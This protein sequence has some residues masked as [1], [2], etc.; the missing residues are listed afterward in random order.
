VISTDAATLLATSKDVVRRYT[1]LYEVQQD[2][3]TR[4]VICT[5]A[6]SLCIGEVA[7]HHVVGHDRLLPPVILVYGI[8]VRN[9][10]GTVS[11]TF[12]QVE[13]C[14]AHCIVPCVGYG[15]DVAILEPLLSCPTLGAHV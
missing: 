3:H 9:K 1:V 6:S 7:G 12:S 4:T 13:V 5:Q 10:Q 8:C 2:K 14:V 15:V 11:L